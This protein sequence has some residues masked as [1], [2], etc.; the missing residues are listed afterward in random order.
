MCKKVFIERY[1]IEYTRVYNTTPEIGASVYLVFQ[2]YNRYTAVHNRCRCCP[3]FGSLR[4]YLCVY[5]CVLSTH[6]Y[7]FVYLLVYLRHIVYTGVDLGAILYTSHT[8]VHT[9]RF[10][11]VFEY[12]R[13]CALYAQVYKKH[14]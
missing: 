12:T 7:S 5:L 13:V 11:I 14:A 6:V 10:P 8:Q 9:T 3:I 4:A 2:V 1:T